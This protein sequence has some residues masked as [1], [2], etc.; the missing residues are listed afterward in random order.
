MLYISTFSN[1]THCEKVGAK[2]EGA[3]KGTE[4]INND[5]WSTKLQIVQKII[6]P[7][8]FGYNPDI[9]TS[10]SSGIDSLI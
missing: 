4:G 9:T 1:S 5:Q 7:Y 2:R 6:P 10:Y 3:E 8:P